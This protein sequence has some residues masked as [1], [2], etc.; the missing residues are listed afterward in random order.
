[1][2]RSGRRR[3]GRSPWISKAYRRV[4]NQDAKAATLAL[5]RRWPARAWLL[6]G[7]VLLCGVKWAAAAEPRQ[8]DARALR[9]QRV[10]DRVR[11]SLEIPEEV[12]VELV[13]VNPR[14]ASV[15]PLAD[16]PGIYLL[17]VQRGFLEQLADDELEAMVAH[18]L[19][20][21]WI[22]TH[23]PYLQTEPLANR[24]AMRRVSREQLERVYV[25]LWGV[26]GYTQDLAT[27]LGV[28]RSESAASNATPAPVTA[29]GVSPAAPDRP[30]P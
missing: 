17:S 10:V 9:V 11:V 28:A 1:M 27:F 8:A 22:Y 12:R 23:H 4:C 2:K 21:V 13:D 29:A 7:L 19:G 24:V 25:K 14:V 16:A 3:L 5:R 6:G 15:Q 30:R 26:T 20:H 18:E